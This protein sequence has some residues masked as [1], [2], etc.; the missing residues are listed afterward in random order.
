MDQK[1][2]E[3][4]LD[5][6]KAAGALA[7]TALHTISSTLNAGGGYLSDFQCMIMHVLHQFL[8]CAVPLFVLATGAGFLTAERSC[9]Y[10]NMKK[11]IIKV[12]ACIIVFGCLFGGV[13]ML[14]E[15][16]QIS[17]RILCL[18]ILTDSTWAHMWYLYRLLGV[19]L[20]MPLLSAFMKH[21]DVKEQIIFAGL[22]LF[23]FCVYPYGAGL[24]GFIPAEIMPVSGIWL[25]YVTA[26]GV[27]GGM[28][29]NLKKYRWLAAAGILIGGAAVFWESAQGVEHVLDEAH[30]FELLLAISL[31]AEIRILCEKKASVPKLERLAQN[32]LGIYIIHPIFIHVCVK[33][34]H[35]NPQYHM[36]LLT[37]PFTILII[38][39]CSAAAAGVLRKLPLVRKYLL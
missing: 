7:V 14:A 38:F 24:A 1:V 5:V 20:C 9:S 18:K 8:Y 3:R 4:Y 23:F 39:A 21:S 30:P 11:H 15:G 33:L 13:K 19:Y 22:L 17:L 31:F 26:G 2:R 16:E 25:F 29:E 27:I 6:V 35:F 12:T 32:A 36:P 10:G 37:L 34:L 28:R